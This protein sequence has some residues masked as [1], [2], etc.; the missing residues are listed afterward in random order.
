M[1]FINGSCFSKQFVKSHIWQAACWTSRKHLLPACVNWLWPI[2]CPCNPKP[3]SGGSSYLPFSGVA[4][5][6]EQKGP[7]CLQNILQNLNTKLSPNSPS[8]EKGAWLLW[9]SSLLEEEVTG[10]GATE[11]TYRVTNPC[12]LLL[13]KTEHARGR[14]KAACTQISKVGKEEG[15][16]IVL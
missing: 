12:W 1:G 2:P 13:I 16:P 8:Q 10:E 15:S 7:K 14:Y 9:E 3:R 6:W 11:Y 5:V 4:Q